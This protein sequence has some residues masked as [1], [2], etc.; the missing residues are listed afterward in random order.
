MARTLTTNLLPPPQSQW[1]FLIYWFERLCDAEK[2]SDSGL[3]T[4]QCCCCQAASHGRRSSPVCVGPYYCRLYMLHF[5]IKCALCVCVCVCVCVC[6]GAHTQTRNSHCDTHNQT[7]Q[8]HVTAQFNTGGGGGL[9]GDSLQPSFVF[10]V[11]VMQDTSSFYW[12]CTNLC[13]VW[14]CWQMHRHVLNE[15]KLEVIGGIVNS[16]RALAWRVPSN[17]TNVLISYVP[18][19]F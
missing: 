15:Y 14:R 10:E 12:N 3:K 2:R 19:S 1:Y 6:A 17:T 9:S 16:I 18:V 13:F 11:V 7:I 4:E 5:C 8:T